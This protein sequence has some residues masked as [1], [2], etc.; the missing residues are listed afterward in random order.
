MIYKR[1]AWFT[2]KFI[3]GVILLLGLFIISVDR[4]I[5]LIIGSIFSGYSLFE[6][7][8][9]IGLLVY[10]FITITFPK[11]I[12]QVIKNFISSRN[13][14]IKISDDKFHYL[15]RNESHE[16]YINE[17]IIR[18]EIKKVKKRP[19]IEDLLLFISTKKDD[20]VEVALSCIYIGLKK[21]EEML[22]LL[23][24]NGAT[25]D[26]YDKESINNSNDNVHGDKWMCS[27][28]GMINETYVPTCKKC[29][30]EFNPP[31]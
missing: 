10:G 28:C 8:Y 2:T 12:F 7:N 24:S 19:Y 14:V 3:L 25:V 9:L 11:F 13:F 30:K 17:M 15:V 16:F 23:L 18:T 5:I 1:T 31:N 29:G 6:A 26:G 27:K 22:N 21:F 20:S 4:F